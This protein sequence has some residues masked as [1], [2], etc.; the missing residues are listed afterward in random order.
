VL[1]SNF[2]TSKVN[3]ED[4]R[5]RN[6][7]ATITLVIIPCTLIDPKTTKH[8]QNCCTFDSMNMRLLSCNLLISVNSFYGSSITTT[9]AL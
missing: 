7:D 6:V 9:I 4:R 8:I 2:K 3:E 1:S 5:I